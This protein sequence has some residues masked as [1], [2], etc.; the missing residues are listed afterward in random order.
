MVLLRRTAKQQG[1][2]LEG[3]QRERRGCSMAKGFRKGI[4]R[5]THTRAD[6]NLGRVLVDLS[7]PKVVE[8]LGKKWYTLTVRDNFSRFT[9]V[10]FVRH[11]SDA[12]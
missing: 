8:S 3:E 4:K 7:G 11:K 9:W 5:S 6:N 2:V 1:M 10:C 12:A